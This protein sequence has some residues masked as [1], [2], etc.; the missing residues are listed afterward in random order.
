MNLFETVKENV[1]MRQ[2]AEFCGIDINRSNMCCCPFHNDDSPSM[3]LYDDHYYCAM[4]LPQKS[5]L[6][7]IDLIEILEY[8]NFLTTFN[9]IYGEMR[10]NPVR[11]EYTYGNERRYSPG[12]ISMLVDDMKMRVRTKREKI[13]QLIRISALKTCEFIFL[14]RQLKILTNTSI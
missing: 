14:N 10:E 3:K 7:G 1:S 12:T 4:F 2:A 9:A 6:L 11:A 5:I 13:K 8:C